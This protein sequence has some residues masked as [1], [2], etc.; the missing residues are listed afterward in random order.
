MKLSEEQVRDIVVLRGK[1]QERA[2]ELQEE[3][4]MTNLN[5]IALDSALKKSSFMKAS[6]YTPDEAPQPAARPEGP[7]G[8]QPAGQD[9]PAEMQPPGGGRPEEP[10]RPITTG[11]G[12]VVGR[13]T[14]NEES[15][16]I[17]LEPDVNVSEETPPFRTFFISRVIGEM[18]RKDSQEVEAGRL[19]PESVITCEVRSE[20]GRIRE[21]TI[22]NYRLEE[23][24]REIAST[25]KWVLS[26]M[27]EHAG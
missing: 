24:A 5:I 21:I 18:K 1:L 7:E 27:L 10:S 26:R 14:T 6:E 2:V 15:I 4:E 22:T 25:T 19:G 20:D 8:A 16:S 17:V 13:I 11:S 3:L 9:R 23:R 12:E